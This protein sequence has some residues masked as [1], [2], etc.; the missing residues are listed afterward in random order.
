MILNDLI[1]PEI[2]SKINTK[3][4]Y[5]W[6]DGLAVYLVRPEGHGILLYYI[7]YIL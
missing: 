6:K 1:Y 3:L 4:Q 5:L 2:A 7:Y